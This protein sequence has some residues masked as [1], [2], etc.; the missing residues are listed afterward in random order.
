MQEFIHLS[1]LLNTYNSLNK[2]LISVTDLS[3]IMSHPLLDIPLRERYH[4]KKFCDIAK[5]TATGYRRCRRCRRFA[6][7]KAIKTG[8]LFCG[9]CV[10]GLYEIGLPVVVGGKVL[11]VVYVGNLMPDKAFA[12]EKVEKACQKTGV[13]PKIL[14]AKL[15][16][17]QPVTDLQTYIDIAETVSSYIKLV[18]KT[19]PQDLGGNAHWVI[20]EMKMYARENFRNPIKLSDRAKHYGFNEKYIGRLFKS[21]TDVS[22]S[23]Y[24]NRL[25]LNHAKNLLLSTEKSIIEVAL[26][27]G[28]EN[29]TYFNRCFKRELGLTPTEFRRQRPMD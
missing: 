22:F 1:K 6:D 9:Y 13:D 15:E 4:T 3:G 24:V 10:N 19:F 26:D 12:T 21:T 7:R 5:S 17:A 8:E 27:S 29:V 20:R 14:T 16:D 2:F 25:R 18:F 11:A 28:F 23:N